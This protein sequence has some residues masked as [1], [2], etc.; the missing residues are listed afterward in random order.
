MAKQGKLSTPNLEGEEVNSPLGKTYRIIEFAGQGGFGITYRVKDETD[1]EC[2]LKVPRTDTAATGDLDVRI[3]SMEQESRVLKDLDLVDNVPKELAYFETNI[4]GEKL[5]ILVMELAKGI[6]LDK[7]LNDS[8]NSPEM[9][10][11]AIVSYV[12]KLCETMAEIH[13]RDLIHRDIKSP[14]LFIEPHPT[15]PK[16]TIIDFGIAAQV[17][18][19]TLFSEAAIQGSLREAQSKFYAPPEQGSGT[20]SPKV[21]IFAVGAVATELFTWRV[22]PTMPREHTYSPN[23]VIPSLPKIELI[24]EDIDKVIQRAT[25]K[26]RTLRFATMHEFAMDLNGDLSPSLYPRIITS[27]GEV[28]PLTLERNE[29][30][31]IGRKMGTSLSGARIEVR[32]RTAKGGKDFLSRHHALIRMDSDDVIRLYDFG[33]S[34]PNGKRQSTNKTVWR[35]PGASSEEWRRVPPEGIPLMDSPVEV[36]LGLVKISKHKDAEGHSIPEGAYKQLSYHP[37]ESSQGNPLG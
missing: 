24:P 22:K 13:S 2:I 35:F 32:E 4:E 15:N 6:A 16:L 30:I 20:E 28:K 17:A 3:E 36:G 18:T 11:E 25:M 1:L 7:Y 21:D 23:E 10:T 26:D 34:R 9:N 29:E 14:N 8:M 12:T 19:S 27:S 37:P 5:P 33:I 31:W